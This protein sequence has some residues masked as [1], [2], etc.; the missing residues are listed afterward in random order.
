[1]TFSELLIQEHAL[2]R[3]ALAVL[4]KMT[5]NAENG[6]PAGKH[7]VNALLIFLHYFADAYHQGKEEDVLFPLLRQSQSTL[8]MEDRMRSQL[9]ALLREHNEERSL[10]ERTQLTL[11]S[12]N[13][14]GF[15]ENARKLKQI[16]SE[17]ALK[18][19]Q[20]LFPMAEKILTPAEAQ[21]ASLRMEQADAKFGSAQGK[22]LLEL[23]QELEERYLQKAA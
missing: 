23:L 14:S 20:V 12:E 18:E 21:D 16:L 9:E 4:E 1:M 6:V 10:I 5:E 8:R 15:I 19:E 3:R 22:L 7:D 13:T 17:H 2:I 11:F